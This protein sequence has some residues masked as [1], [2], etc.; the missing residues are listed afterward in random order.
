MWIVYPEN[1]M[2]YIALDDENEMM[3]FYFFAFN[4][5]AGFITALFMQAFSC[6][7]D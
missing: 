5:C 3:F 4:Q 2:D 6:P 7:R 1:L